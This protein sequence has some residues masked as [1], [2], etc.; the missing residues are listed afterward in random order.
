MGAS[1]RSEVTGSAFGL[2]FRGDPLPDPVELVGEGAAL[3]VAVESPIPADGVDL[4]GQGLDEGITRSR[5]RQRDPH[6]LEQPQ[7]S[8]P[9]R[10]PPP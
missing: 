5:S 6:R 10:E 2:G 3:A 4:G 9:H 8:P 7:S 1:R